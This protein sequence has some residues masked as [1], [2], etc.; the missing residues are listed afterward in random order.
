MDAGETVTFTSI[1]DLGLEGFVDEAL[2]HFNLNQDAVRHPDYLYL[3]AATD[4]QK[5]VLAT[6]A[7]FARAGRSR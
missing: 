1:Y 2:P 3:R 6:R 5:L 4:S 7:V